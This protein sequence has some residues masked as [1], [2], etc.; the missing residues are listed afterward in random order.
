MG[1]VVGMVVQVERLL[2]LK[3][4][5]VMV[6]VAVEEGERRDWIRGPGVIAAALVALVL[7]GRLEGH[8]ARGNTV[9]DLERADLVN[10]RRRSCWVGVEGGGSLIPLDFLVGEYKD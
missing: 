1:V 9:L 10:R 3:K 4:A 6:V 2:R 7:T 8:V 5:A